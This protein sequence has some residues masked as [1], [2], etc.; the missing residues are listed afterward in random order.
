MLL[1]KLCCCQLPVLMTSKTLLKTVCY[2]KGFEKLKR[3]KAVKVIENDIQFWAEEQRELIECDCVLFAGIECSVIAF[4]WNS[5]RFL[6]LIHF[7]RHFVWSHQQWFVNRYITW[8]IAKKM[9]QTSNK[10]VDW[11]PVI[12]TTTSHIP[13][14]DILSP[15]M[16]EHPW[17]GTILLGNQFKHRFSDM[18]VL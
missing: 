17:L 2:N 6:K 4:L 18:F 3:K 12:E 14:N 8:P 7:K 5:M 15:R 1:A 16:C 11:F 13:W 9:P 10:Y